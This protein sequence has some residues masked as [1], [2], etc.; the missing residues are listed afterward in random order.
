MHALL[1]PMR[2]AC[3]ALSDE[4]VRE[5]QC[6]VPI[7]VPQVGPGQL[8]G[9]EPHSAVGSKPFRE[10]GCLPEKLV[11]TRKLTPAGDCRGEVVVGAGGSHEGIVVQRDPEALLDLP[12]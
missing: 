7:A 5:P 12:H 11:V 8:C 1:L 4:L 9:G 3:L 10:S 6:L 2:T